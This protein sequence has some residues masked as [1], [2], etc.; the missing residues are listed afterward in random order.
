VLLG[1]GCSRSLEFS[2]NDTPA[3]FASG[4][5]PADFEAAIGTFIDAALNPNAARCPIP[6]TANENR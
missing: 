6:T 3:Q 5:T 2:V 4:V 1:E